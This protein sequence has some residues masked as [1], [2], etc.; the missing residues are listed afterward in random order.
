MVRFLPLIFQPPKHVWGR[1]GVVFVPFPVTE[2]AATKEAWDVPLLVPGLL[3][4]LGASLC[5]LCVN[6]AAL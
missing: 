4:A 1:W 6:S 2:A 5:L 3:L